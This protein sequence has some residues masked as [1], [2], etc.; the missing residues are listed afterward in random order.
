MRR[1][2]FLVGVAALLATPSVPAQDLQPGRNF[3]SSD[4]P[5]GAGRSENVDVGD[6]DGDGDFDVLIA[7]GGDG[8]PQQNRLYRNDGS[9]TFTD[10]TTTQLAPG[11][12]N[13]RSRDCEF[14][15]VEDD[16]DLDI[17]ISNRGASINGE[18]S[19]FFDNNGSGFYSET[20]DTRWGTLV[21]V[22]LSA[23]VLGGNEGPWLDWSCDCDFAD[24][25]I[26]GDIDLFHS[27]YG[28][29]ISG[30]RVSRVFMNDGSG[31]FDEEWPWANA[32]ADI[33][34]HTLDIDLADFDGDFDIDVAVSSRDSQA[35]FFVNNTVNPV[36]GG[37]RFADTTSAALL[38]GG[39][40][41]TGN[42]NY[43]AEYADLDTDGDFD[44]W[45][46]NL[47]G[48]QDKLARNDGS[49]T[50]SIWDPLVG[51]PVV[52]ENEVDFI[53]YDADGDLDAFAANFS[54]TNWL[55][56]STVSQGGTIQYRRTG[57]GTEPPELPTSGNTGTTLDG[58][59]ADMDGDG[60][61]DLL[62]A[63]DG[64]QQ[65]RYF[66][67]ALGVPDTTAPTFFQVESVADKPLGD[68]ARV[69]AQVR[70]NSA[71]YIVGHY[72][73]DL[74]YSV[75]TTEVSV[76]MF[77]QGG[78]QFMGF[79]PGNIDGTISYR[80]EATDRAGNT[81][82]SA[83]QSFVQGSGGTPGTW[84]DLGFAKAGTN[85]FPALV[86]TGP[87][88]GGTSNQI[89]LTNALGSTPATL[90]V[91]L[92]N[93]SAPFKGG[94]LVPSPDILINL[95]TSPAGTITLP[96]TWPTGIPLG[97]K[98]YWQFWITDAGAANGLSASNGLE[99]SAGSP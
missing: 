34:W 55:Y 38:A 1:N 56:R 92:T 87:L 66:E 35:R 20:S 14:V 53:D 25:D 42:N 75:G 59:A 67:N 70:D 17:Y 73:V 93:I 72:D 61:E 54:G 82:V 9:A 12:P 63:N 45:F 78:Q 83:T 48:N 97:T 80:V 65:N 88:Q 22:P 39:V 43:E 30:N 58:E 62:L 89:D 74:I 26:D 52:D 23:Q 51:D 47:K 28:P 6:I 41:Q 27:S 40:T 77:S 64:N 95:G 98:L 86:G 5:F 19:R 7:N 46:K 79:I 68:D 99:S 60:D 71:Y 32:S 21:S 11:A 29:N 90:F 3:P 85:G 94:T 44:I 13:G 33:E 36:G 10:V 76:D 2:L 24:L 57:N 37:N 31:R 49:A 84:T 8:S 69:I 15:D 96:F 81:G 50:F 4:N 91:G 18:V 16:G